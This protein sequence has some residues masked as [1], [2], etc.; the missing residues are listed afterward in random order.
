MAIK[1]K[2]KPRTRRS[3]TPGP[4]PAYVPVRRPLVQRRGFQLGVVAVLIAAVAGGILY[5]VARERNQNHAAEQ[6]QL[7]KNIAS[8]YTTRVQ[9]AIAGVGQA[10]SVS[11]TLLPDLKTQIDALKSGSGTPDDV[12]KA[13][14]GLADQAESAADALSR[15][16]PASM[17]RG[18]GVE[19]T[20]FVRDLV[21]ANVKMENGLRMDAVAAGVL[22]QAA[23]SGGAEAKAL[24]ERADEARTTAET[25]FLSGYSDWTNAQYA[26]GI[27]Q[28]APIAP[29]S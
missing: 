13:A 14:K 19:D 8:T 9:T 25:V 5:G 11:F 29:G 24:L 15:I 12:A 17:I 26:G 2:S 27:F 28:P 20:A 16:D 1:G 21:N 10:E 6:E 22:E 18:K 3:V 23:A 4:R 7:L